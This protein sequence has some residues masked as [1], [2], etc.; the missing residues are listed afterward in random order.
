MTLEQCV[1]EI[2]KKIDAGDYFDSHAVINELLLQKDYR[3][4][5]LRGYSKDSSIAQYHG[6]IAQIIT[7][8][9]VATQIGNA[10]SHTIYGELLDNTL[11]QK[12]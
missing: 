8:K 12:I 3:L 9:K 4:A 2:L 7:S 10:K 5:Y 1:E 6:K 11:W